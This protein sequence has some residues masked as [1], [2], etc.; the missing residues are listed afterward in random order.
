[1]PP[2]DHDRPRPRRAADL[3]VEALVAERCLRLAELPQGVLDN[4]SGG[5]DGSI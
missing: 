2:P 3:L 1:M 4:T 5:T